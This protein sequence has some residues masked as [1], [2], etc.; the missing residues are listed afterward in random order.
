[1]ASMVVV[2]RG[3]SQQTS[4]LD[5]SGLNTLE[6]SYYVKL[7]N[8]IWQ[9]PLDSASQWHVGY[10]KNTTSIS[11]SAAGTLQLNATFAS[12]A[13]PQAVQLYRI[14][15]FS[16]DQNP[17]MKISIA[18]SVGIHYG[19]RI[20]GMDASGNTFLA[21]SESSY[22]QHRKGLGEVENLTINAVVEADKVN[23][24]FPAAGS[25]IT[26]LLF[27][28]EASP[29]QSGQFSLNVSR[30]TV[31]TGND[32]SFNAAN[33]V[34]DSMDGIVL[35]VNATNSLGYQ[36]DQFFQG[37]VDFYVSGTSD[38]VYTVYYMH[39]LTVLGQ[40]F[41]Y[42]SSARTYNIAFF[43]ATK[44]RNYPQILTGNNT[45]SIVLAP[46]SGSFQSFQL[47]G[48]SVRYLSQ[49]A[50]NATPTD[51]DTRTIFTYYLVF[52][53]VTPVAIVILV[54]RLFSHETRQAS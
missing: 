54:S 11:M 30:I 31:V 50:L 37:Y 52:L 21:W 33:K 4:V 10:Q 29:G 25:S 27:Y 48:F 23:G 49:A 39:H 5:V 41:D 18:A 20:S 2:L 12:E 13:Y 17:V 3:K 36:D 9:D 53:F 6:S 1:M 45:F 22:L 32:Y 47:E 38:L 7:N 19:V 46:K 28:V 14:M 35:T 15:N 42:S 43:S 24:V 8:T 44:V 40:G 26:G 34:T 16:L 51:I